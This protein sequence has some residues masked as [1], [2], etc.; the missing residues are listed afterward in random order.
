[1]SQPAPAPKE[2]RIPLDSKKYEFV[3]YGTMPVLDVEIKSGKIKPK[4]DV[5][6]VER[7]TVELYHPMSGEIFEA[8]FSK[9]RIEVDKDGSVTYFTRDASSVNFSMFLK[10]NLS[11]S[12]T[13]SGEVVIK[14]A[15]RILSITQR[16][17][18]KKRMGANVTSDSI[19]LQLE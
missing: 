2:S 5:E 18:E 3:A 10:R 1:L 9:G 16:K 15:S 17:N 19:T 8:K 12:M 11:I 7:L 4:S 13:E 6:K 14:S